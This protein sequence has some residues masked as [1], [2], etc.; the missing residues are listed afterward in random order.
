MIFPILLAWAAAADNINGK[1]SA[2]LCQQLRDKNTI[3]LVY[4][5]NKMLLR[6]PVLQPYDALI[7]C[8]QKHLISA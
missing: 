7:D 8:L 1:F 4:L 2:N 3:C 5:E 6:D